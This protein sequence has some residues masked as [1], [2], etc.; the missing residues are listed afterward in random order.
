[1]KIAIL[2]MTALTAAAAIAGSAAAAE[3][4]TD[5]QYLHANRCRGLAAATSSA[6]ADDLAAA[7]KAA[8]RG[9]MPNMV[10]RGEE[11][12]SRAKRAAKREDKSRIEAELNGAC[13]TYLNTGAVQSGAN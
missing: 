6:S 2:S 4:L 13:M 3:R 1:M 5:A 8:D 11:A 10:E 7:V 9:R 12:F